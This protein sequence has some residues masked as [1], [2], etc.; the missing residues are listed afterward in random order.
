MS[1]IK[2]KYI[3]P[4]CDIVGFQQLVS[5]IV[6]Y[7]LEPKVWREEE[8]SEAEDS[9]SP[10]AFRT[11]TRL[12][13]HIAF[14]KDFFRSYKEFTD[15]Q[16]D[17]IEI[18]LEKLYAQFGITGE[19]DF[20]KLRSA[21]YP[22]QRDLYDLSV[23]ELR[24]CGED[25][26]NLYTGET[27]RKICLGL[28]SM[29]VGSESKYFCGHT[30]IADDKFLC[31]GLKGL[32]DTN[33]KLRN[34]VLFN[35]LSYMSNTLIG[36]GNTVAAIDELYLFHPGKCGPRAFSRQ[37]TKSQGRK[38][39]PLVMNLLWGT[40]ETLTI[41][42]HGFKQGIQSR[43]RKIPQTIQ[44][45][46]NRVLSNLTAG[47]GGRTTI[48]LRENISMEPRNKSPIMRKSCPCFCWKQVGETALPT[49]ISG[50]CICLV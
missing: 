11:A 25:D 43:N 14:L 41:G 6:R 20:G 40:T 9:E 49:M 32:M 27:L 48:C 3:K 22:V 5:L 50:G 8:N 24:L 13:Q 4:L 23:K 10:D 15:D 1:K 31:F 26:K 2:S 38:F 47:R 12:S 45:R 18:L 29:C 28:H 46:R 7:V 36:I 35:I 44:R 33:E 30:N 17:T 39:F 21:D 34:A 42:C 37:R 16:I 19:S